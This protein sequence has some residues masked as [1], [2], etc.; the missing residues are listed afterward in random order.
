MMSRRQLL[1]LP[2]KPG[3]KP[4]AASATQ[5]L[6][7]CFGPPWRPCRLEGA[8]GGW[9]NA[10][11]PPAP[12]AAL[13]ARAAI[14]AAQH[15][16]EA[17]VDLVHELR[18]IVGDDFVVTRRDQME[19]Y[20]LDETPQ[21]VKPMAAAHV[22]V[23]KPSNAA[24]I[25]EIVKLANRTLTPVYPRGGGTS[26]VGGPIP[27]KRWH[28]ALPRASRPHRGDRHGE[29]HGRCGVR[30]HDGEAAPRRRSC[31]TALPATSRRRR[32]AGRRRHRLQRGRL[33]GGEVRRREELREGS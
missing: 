6:E 8:N 7:R 14:G 3:L 33:Q 26:T 11:A 13:R 1:E 20:L 32:S 16:K 2:P 22:I 12:R 25:S 15:A 30:S 17:P 4:T 5:V 24:E 29:P 10:P 19:G 27:T 23:V 28:R 18:T 9:H 21:A 31:R